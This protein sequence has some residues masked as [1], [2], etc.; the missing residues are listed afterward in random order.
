MRRLWWQVVHTSGARLYALGAGL[1]ILAFT[2]RYLGPEGRGIVVAAMAWVSMAAAFGSMSLGQV[3]VHFAVGKPPREWIPP[4]L[5][6]LLSVL[7]AAT[8]IAWAV[9]AIGYSMTEGHLFRN[10][11]G[12]V[13]AVAFLSL[14]TLIWADYASSILVCLDDLKVA[15]AAQ[16]AGSSINA[17]LVV[18][19]LDVTPAGVYAPLIAASAAGALTATITFRAIRRRGGGPRID[20]RH[21]RTMMTGA[22]KLHANAVGTYFFTQASLLIVNHY[23]PAGETAFFALAL[24]LLFVAQIAPNAAGLVA[25]TI[26]SKHGPD[27]AWHQQRLLLLQT[28]ALTAALVVAGY[29]LA[30][31]AVTILAGAAFAPAVPLFRMML[32]SLFGMTFSAIMASQ[33]IGRGFFLLASV[34]TLATGLINIIATFFAVRRFGLAGAAWATLVVYAIAVGG[35]GLMALWV[36]RRTSHA[37]VASEPG[38]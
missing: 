8:V 4:T 34:I 27:A 10:L 21:S 25:Y 26:V 9:V 11:T 18:L 13:L 33:W 37:R 35:N 14:P 15:N 32:P 24:Q 36:H 16:V 2:A 20:G 23:R 7:V 22:V 30:P 19:L 6:T 3:A 28:L 31:L 17:F 5:G 38:P 1:I 29:I 12:A